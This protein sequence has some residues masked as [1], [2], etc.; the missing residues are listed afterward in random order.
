GLK[1][2]PR[3]L[4]LCQPLGMGGDGA[5]VVRRPGQDARG[6]Q[7]QQGEHH[8]RDEHLHQGEARCA[9]TVAGCTVHRDS[10][11]SS[12][13]ASTW[14]PPAARTSTRTLTRPSTGAG[15]RRRSHSH[16]RPPDCTLPP[17][18]T[19]ADPSSSAAST[20]WL[21]ATTS[22]SHCSCKIARVRVFCPASCSLARSEERRGG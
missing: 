3:A 11:S 13:L 22:A 10:R 12:A 19:S 4:Q 9:V 2:G 8:Q 14:P 7:S 20:A 17:P 6:G 18:A 15:S 21:P 5:A 1:Q 16:P